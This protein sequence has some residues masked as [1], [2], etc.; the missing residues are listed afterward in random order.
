MNAEKRRTKHRTTQKLL[1]EEESYLIRGA[2]FNIYKNFRNTQ[3]EVVY[4]RSLLEELKTKGLRVEK[5][6][7]LPVYYLGKKVGI[8]TPD[9][10]IN[11]TIVIELKAKPF[12]HRDDIQQFWHYLKNSEF[13]L[14]FLV[15]F[16]EPNGVRIIR[17]I[18]DRVRRS[19]VN[20]SV[21]SAE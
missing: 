5:E 10:V 21:G 19:S 15:N 16:G 6:K 12:L 13:K 8:Y 18:Y 11:D 7:R 2:C 9:L 1:Y 14:G 4:Q 17:K 20:S 3:K